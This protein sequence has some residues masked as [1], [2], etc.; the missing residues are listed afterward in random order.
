MLTTDCVISTCRFL[1]RQTSSYDSSRILSA[2]NSALRARASQNEPRSRDGAFCYPPAFFTPPQIIQCNANVE[3]WKGFLST[4]RPIYKG[5]ALNID[6]CL[7]AFFIPRVQLSDLMLE[8]RQRAHGVDPNWSSLFGRLKI[9]TT[10]GPKK[11]RF[12][13]SFNPASARSMTVTVEKYGSISVEQFYQ[14]GNPIL[15]SGC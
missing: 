11:T 15:V 7:R 5:L 4:I 1:Q 2:F 14:R 10:I 3:A 12:V 6:A 9:T 13:K 8:L